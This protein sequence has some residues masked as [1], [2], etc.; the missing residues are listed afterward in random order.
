[1]RCMS[2]FELVSLLCMIPI[3]RCGTTHQRHSR[4]PWRGSH[5]ESSHNTP[6]ATY[7]TKGNTNFAKSFATGVPT[8]IDDGD[9]ATIPA[10]S[11]STGFAFISQL[12]EQHT[13]CLIS[14]S[15]AGII[16]QVK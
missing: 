12:I 8:I 3:D 6:H 11:T 16:C 4:S 10:T 9:R 14:S 1:M 7:L 13:A 5:G 15:I 2:C